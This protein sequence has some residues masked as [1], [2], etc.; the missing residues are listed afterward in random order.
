MNNNIAAQLHKT[1]EDPEKCKECRWLKFA[2]GEDFVVSYCYRK[3]FLDKE[4][5]CEVQE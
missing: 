3:W 1:I 5:D 4:C 2:E